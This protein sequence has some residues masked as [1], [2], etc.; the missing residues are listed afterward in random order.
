MPGYALIN[1]A[2]Q[3]PLSA[4]IIDLALYDACN[5]ISVI[6]LTHLRQV[7]CAIGFKAKAIICICEACDAISV[8]GNAFVV[9]YEACNVIGSIGKAHFWYIVYWWPIPRYADQLVSIFPRTAAHVKIIAS[10]Y[11]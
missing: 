8:K 11:S 4:I 7:A 3:F 6:V 9:P 2:N 1:G 10:I 5:T